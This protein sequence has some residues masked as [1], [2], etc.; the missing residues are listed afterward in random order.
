MHFPN[1]HLGDMSSR[2]LLYYIVLMVKWF[3]KGNKILMMKNILRI[4]SRKANTDS[5]FQPCS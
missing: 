4:Q 5:C 1:L 2:R 3:L